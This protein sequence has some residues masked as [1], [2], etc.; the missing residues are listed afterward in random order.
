MAIFAL[1]MLTDFV[2][3]LEPYIPQGL[4]TMIALAMLSWAAC[5]YVL[6]RRIRGIVNKSI[7][8]NIREL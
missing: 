7:I 6:R 3:G 8:D 4:G 1:M 5:R 2:E